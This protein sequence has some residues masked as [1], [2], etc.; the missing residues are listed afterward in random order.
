MSEGFA[1]TSGFTHK[2]EQR[3]A[4][5]P[6]AALFVEFRLIEFARQSVITLQQRP[7]LVGHRG[8]QEKHDSLEAHFQEL[9]DTVFDSTLRRKLERGHSSQIKIVE[10]TT[11]FSHFNFYLF[12]TACEIDSHIARNPAIAI[13]RDSFRHEL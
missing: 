7:L 13:V 4:A 12:D 6:R 5:A 3:E 9:V 2:K 10:R 11:A 1:S 8:R